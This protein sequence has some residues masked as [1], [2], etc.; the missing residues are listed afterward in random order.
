MKRATF[1]FGIGIIAFVIIALLLYKFWLVTLNLTLG[2][3]L[4]LIFDKALIFLERKGIKGLLA[5]SL[6]FLIVSSMILAFIL[7]VSIPLFDQLQTFVADFP[8]HT[9][10]IQEESKNIIESFP[11]IEQYIE[12]GRD[13]L[14]VAGKKILS[15]SATI[16]G[17]ALTAVLLSIILLAS[18]STLRETILEQIPNEYF[19][20]TVSVAHRIIEHLQQFVVARTVQ[21][22]AIT[23]IYTI[24]FFI[25]GLPFPLLLGLVSGLLNII[26]YIG[27]LLTLIPVVLAAFIGG[28]LTLAFW[29]AGIVILA[30]LIDN[31]VLQTFLVSKFVD[32]HPVMAFIVTLVFGQLLG[33]IG[34]IV[35]IPIYV[36]SKILI[37]GLWDYARAL[38]RH[39][40]ILGHQETQ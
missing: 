16:L 25:I 1:L 26:P 22:M 37:G 18:R 30:Q 35:G 27:P 7:F 8:A 17:S 29:A 15:L 5:Y 13:Q 2:F 38:Q 39:E 6:L 3:L 4:Y 40:Y 33:P 14:L 28:G 31:T 12:N 23:V 21:T 11:Y 32:V 24:G 10:K 20:V 9:A 34:M 36:I 19:E